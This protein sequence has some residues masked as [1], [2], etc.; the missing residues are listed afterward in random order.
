MSGTSVGASGETADDMD[1][2]GFKAKEALLITSIVRA[3]E[4]VQ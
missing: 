4:G 1:T 2:S 3:G